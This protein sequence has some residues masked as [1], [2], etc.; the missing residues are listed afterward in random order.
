MPD[1]LGGQ[2]NVQ[3]GPGGVR[4]VR[5]FDVTNLFDCRLLEPGEVPLVEEVFSASVEKP[6][7]VLRDARHLEL[8]ELR[9]SEP[10]VRRNVSA[11][12]TAG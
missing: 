5:Q 1:D 12:K 4:A 3:I 11:G 7:A 8:H 6:E 2:V 10:K 9:L